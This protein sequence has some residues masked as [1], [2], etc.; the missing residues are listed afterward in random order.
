MQKFFFFLAFVF[1]C[2]FNSSLTFADSIKF[3]DSPCETDKGDYYYYTDYVIIRKTDQYYLTSSGVNKD[4]TYYITYYNNYN[5]EFIVK[6]NAE[7]VYNVNKSIKT[8]TFQL[9]DNE[10]VKCQHSPYNDTFSDYSG[11][12]STIFNS[13]TYYNVLYNTSSIFREDGT[14]FKESLEYYDK[15]NNLSTTLSKEFSVSNVKDIFKT[16]KYLV[17]MLLSV[18]I[19]FV[20]IKKCFN[21]I[22]NML[23]GE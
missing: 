11:S 21:C 7:F 5:G 16:F 14:I 20:A 22:K 1:F 6:R 13:I 17:P 8:L 23:G 9:V 2:C 15:G 4:Y 12:G 10:W 19:I 3:P 18:V